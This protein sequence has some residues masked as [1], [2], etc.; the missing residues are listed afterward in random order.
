M[1]SAIDVIASRAAEHHLDLY[2]HYDDSVPATIAADP[3]R[4]RQILINL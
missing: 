4:L 3:T 2:C 1:E